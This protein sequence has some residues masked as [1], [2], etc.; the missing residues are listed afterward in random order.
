MANGCT[1]CGACHA[2]TITSRRWITYLVMNSSEPVWVRSAGDREFERALMVLP[3]RCGGIA[4][5]IL[6]R[7][8]QFE[9]SASTYVTQPLVEML[10]PPLLPSEPI[11]SSIESSSRLLK[12]A[13]AISDAADDVR[14]TVPTMGETDILE[15]LPT[16][17]YRA[18]EHRR[19][20][21]S[22]NSRWQICSLI[23]HCANKC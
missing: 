1:M 12:W 3:V 14:D 4:F 10:V 8:A 22:T 5:H 18:A 11:E 19:K 9:H 16:V 6:S 7:M 2:L 17:R 20:K 15:A 21:N 23:C 13:A